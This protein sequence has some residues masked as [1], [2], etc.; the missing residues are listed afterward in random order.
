[1]S[2]TIGTAYVAGYKYGPIREDYRNIAEYFSV[3]SGHLAKGLELLETGERPEILMVQN[4]NR[5]DKIGAAVF[6]PSVWSKA[7]TKVGTP[8]G[9]VHRDYHYQW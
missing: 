9:K 8:Y 7:Y 5:E 6:Y 3:T 1:M 4:P 2:A